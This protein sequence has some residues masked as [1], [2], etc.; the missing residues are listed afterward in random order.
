MV[1]KDGTSDL[2]LYYDFEAMHE[3]VDETRGHTR[4]VDEHIPMALSM[5]VVSDLPDFQRGKQGARRVLQEV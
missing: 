3:K 1:E 4:L 2:R 5:V